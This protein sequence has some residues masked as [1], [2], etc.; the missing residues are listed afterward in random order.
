MAWQ[1]SDTFSFPADHVLGQP[2]FTLPAT[3]GVLDGPI[4][5][6]TEGTELLV[7]DSG[8]HRVLIWDVLDQVNGDP[9]D[10]FI[11]GGPNNGGISARS[12]YLPSGMNGSPALAGQTLWVPDGENHRVLRYDVTR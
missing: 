2:D 3:P 1:A 5:V 4:G 8:G 6:E 10:R 11:G 9:A 7:T 12:L